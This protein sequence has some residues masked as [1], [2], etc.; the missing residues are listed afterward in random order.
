MQIKLSDG[1]VN[2]SFDDSTISIFQIGE[3]VS[4]SPAEN[5]IFISAEL[6]DHAI[7][8]PGEYEV[9]DLE[10]VGFETKH[11]P[12]GNAELFKIA[13]SGIHFLTVLSNFED[14][15]KDAWEMIGQVD[16]LI[17]DMSHVS[18]DISK[19]TKSLVPAAIVIFGGGSKEDLSK[20]LDVEFS[21]ISNSLKFTAKDFQNQEQSTKYYLLKK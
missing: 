14:I 5:Q 10:I 13:G 3:D 9:T 19:L 16:V 18:S 8:H 1:H 6:S 17:V 20:K 7:C 21:Q 2:L 11:K 15:K 4:V 12:E